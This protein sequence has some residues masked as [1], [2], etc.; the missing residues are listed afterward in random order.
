MVCGIG[1]LAVVLFLNIPQMLVRLG[2][3]EFRHQINALGSLP[4]SS[5]HSWPVFVLLGGH[6]HL[7]LSLIGGSLG[8]LRQ[9][10]GGWCV[11]SGIHVNASNRGFPG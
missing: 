8:G 11:S 2:S 3:V 9:C 5:G 4:C 1:K 10:L 7:G 6:C